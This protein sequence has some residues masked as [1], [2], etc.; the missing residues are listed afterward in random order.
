MVPHALS[1]SCQ[2]GAKDNPKKR[3]LKARAYSM[4]DTAAGAKDN[5]K[6]REL[7][8][9]GHDKNYECKRYKGIERI[10]ASVMVQKII[11]RKR[12]LKEYILFSRQGARCKR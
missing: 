12:E 1:L 7:K 10:V 3:E 5:P 6:K 9:E 11:P 4:P 2:Y 8:E